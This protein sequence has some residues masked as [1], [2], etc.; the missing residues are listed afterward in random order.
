MS[1]KRLWFILFTLVFSLPTWAKFTP[2]QVKAVYIYRI[3]SFVYWHHDD[4]KKGIN[5]CAPD[6]DKIKALLINITKDK[7]IRNKPLYVTDSECDVLYISRQE[8]VTL[9]TFNRENTVSVSDL[10]GF[11]QLG[12]V[13]EL[14]TTSGRIKPKVNLN[15][16]GEYTLSANFLRVA[17]IEG[18]HQ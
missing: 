11:T 13:I 2:E 10:E 3:A 15:N 17:D 7:V 9:I 5:I 12:G 4:E 1:F 18:G 8:N 6:D 16:I 14:A